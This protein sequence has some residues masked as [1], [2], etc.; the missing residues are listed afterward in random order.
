VS[1]EPQTDIDRFWHDY[2]TN[3]D[4]KERRLRQFFRHIPR[5]PRCKLCAAPFSGPGAPVMR[6]LG[7]GPSDKNPAV[8]NRCFDYIAKNHGGAEIEISIMFADIRG[9][10][11][12][13]E[14]MSGAAFRAILD[15]FYSVAARAVFDHDGGVDKFVGDEVV[16]FFFPGF[17]GPAHAKAA[18][19]AATDLLRATGHEDP[20]GTWVPV[21]AG[22]AT[23][24]AW[25]GAVGDGTKSDVTAVGDT[26][27]TTARLA[28]AA[29]AGE[30]L[31]T[32][33]AARAAG[34]DPT[35]DHRS[36]DLKGK[37]VA[38]E[39]VLLKVGPAPVAAVG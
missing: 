26:V 35:L 34:L 36:L 2:L 29:K 31:V 33:E 7:S 28:S 18:V 19:S 3:G 21:G 30:I 12:L 8:C 23:G 22:V 16:A 39:V 4:S 25:V 24:L 6:A 11:T 32:I 27:N 9:S 37:T 14:Q 20:R 15:R 10:T 17:V 38:T 13:A 5:G 1:D